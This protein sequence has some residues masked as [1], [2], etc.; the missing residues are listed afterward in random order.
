MLEARLW[1]DAQVLNGSNPSESQGGAGAQSWLKP[2]S[3]NLQGLGKPRLTR[4]FFSLWSRGTQH[5]GCQTC[6]RVSVP[7]WKR[8]TEL[9][10][11][12]CLV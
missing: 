12:A 6:N 7:P 2:H 4:L 5:R 1:L 9:N 3:Q 10:E 8:V 11:V